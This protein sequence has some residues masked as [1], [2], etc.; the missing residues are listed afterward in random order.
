MK[1]PLERVMVEWGRH[2]KLQNLPNCMS[3][4][5]KWRNLGFCHNKEFIDQMDKYFV[6]AV[7]FWFQSSSW[8]SAIAR[9]TQMHRD[10]QIYVL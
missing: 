9:Y 7:I 1:R 10:S 5:G 6:A 2:K 4:K 8:R 3:W